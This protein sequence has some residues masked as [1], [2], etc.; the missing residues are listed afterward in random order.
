MQP[1]TPLHEAT[2]D[3]LDV[4]AYTIP[5]DFPESDGTAEWAATT[6]VVVEARSGA[7]TGLGFTYGDV[8]SA[9]LIDSTL[10]EVVEGRDAMCVSAAWGAM[11]VACRNLG[12]PGVA[13]MAI[14]AVDTALWD[15]KARLLDLPL[16]TLL[17]RPD[18]RFRSTAREASPHTRTPGSPTSSAAG[19]S[20][21]FR[22]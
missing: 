1:N 8:A 14:A 19:P 21:V 16:A 13:S 9:T 2:I 11:V 3:A 20:R 15:L 18:T 22:A 5:T 7:T 6:I 4:S 12:R 17:M 10:R